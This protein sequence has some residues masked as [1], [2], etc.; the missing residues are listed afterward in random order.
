M[1]FREFVPT[2]DLLFQPPSPGYAAGRRKRMISLPPS[3]QQCINITILSDDLV[4]YD[5]Y[6]SLALSTADP[7]V[8]LMPATATVFIL[9]ND[10]EH[11]REI[12]AL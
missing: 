12:I 10:C 4:E 3:Q 11:S 7:D 2:V 6:F 5:E 8:S 1:D 9:N